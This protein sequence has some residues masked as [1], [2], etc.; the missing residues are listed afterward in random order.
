VKAIDVVDKQ[1]YNHA[2]SVRVANG[3]K[4][5]VLTEFV[6][7]KENAVVA[8]CFRNPISEVHGGHR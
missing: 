8:S 4:V 3:N 2:I 1:F 7:D 6:N 5:R